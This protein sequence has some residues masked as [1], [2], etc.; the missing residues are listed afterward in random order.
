M[1][2]MTEPYPPAQENLAR[3]DELCKTGRTTRTVAFG[4]SAG[5]SDA[6]R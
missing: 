6:L 3:L 2:I 5:D 1:A 4:D